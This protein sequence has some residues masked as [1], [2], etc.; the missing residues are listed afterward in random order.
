[1]VQKSVRFVAQ[2]IFEHMAQQLVVVVPKVAVHEEPQLAA[3][4]IEAQPL[5]AAHEVLPLK[6]LAAAV[7]HVVLRL[8]AEPPIVVQEVLA[9]VHGNHQQK[10]KHQQTKDS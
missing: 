9:I 7:Q 3:A 2:P 4:H 1:M 10:K 6:Q 5:V 8:A